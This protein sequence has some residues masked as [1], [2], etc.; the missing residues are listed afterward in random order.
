MG[1]WQRSIEGASETGKQQQAVILRM[2]ICLACAPGPPVAKRINKK[3]NLIKVADPQQEMTIKIN[4]G[5][6]GGERIPHYLS[7]GYIFW[8]HVLY[9]CFIYVF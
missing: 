7:T 9:T 8:V 1:P 5:K 4:L 6:K 2:K 3:E